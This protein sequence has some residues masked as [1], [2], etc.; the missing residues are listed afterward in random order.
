ML[1]L[2]QVR[3][4]LADRKPK[5]VAEATGLSYDTVWRVQKGETR[6]VT[7]DVVKR[8]SDYLENKQ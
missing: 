4:L 8:L 1:D 5:V 2:A 3:T 7:Y 6:A